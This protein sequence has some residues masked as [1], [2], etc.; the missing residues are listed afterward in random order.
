MLTCAVK[1]HSFSLSVQ[2]SPL[3]TTPKLLTITVHAVS[4]AS[5]CSLII[6]QQG[7]EN[8][9]PS[10]ISCPWVFSKGLHV[11]QNAIDWAPSWKGTACGCMSVASTEHSGELLAVVVSKWLFDPLRV[12]L[13]KNLGCHLLRTIGMEESTELLRP[14]WLK[15]ELFDHVQRR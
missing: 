11:P 9:V 14:W 3:I 13:R 2:D 12:P 10:F 15:A 1:C 6:M 4:S 5:S 8:L 7:T